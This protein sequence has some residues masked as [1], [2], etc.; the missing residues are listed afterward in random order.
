MRPLRVLWV[1]LWIV[2]VAAAAAG[3]ELAT[4][5]PFQAPGADGPA[6]VVAMPPAVDGAQ[7]LVVT[8]PSGTTIYRLTPVGAPGPGPG[9]APLVGLAK[10]VHD[11]AVANVAPERRV[12]SPGLAAN[13]TAIAAQIAA[14]TL[15]TGEDVQRA[16]KEANQKT[17]GDKAAA[18]QTFF[19]AL[20]GRFQ[21]LEA[22]SKLA[23]PDQIRAAMLEVAAG[24]GAVK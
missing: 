18:W 11:L 20:A 16:A 21:T 17:L 2:L 3:G 5:A 12:D 9:P 15:K 10:E 8:T 6:Q 7:Y 19:A 1:A 13:Y 4:L 23:T 14:G 22:E 24:L